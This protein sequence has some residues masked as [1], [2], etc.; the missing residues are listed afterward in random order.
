MTDNTRD[1]NDPIAHLRERPNPEVDRERLIE[2]F[3]ELK[4]LTYAFFESVPGAFIILDSR[5]HLIYLNGDAKKMFTDKEASLIGRPLEAISPKIFGH[6]L[7]PKVIKPLLEGKEETALKYSNLLHKWFKISA[8]ESE[9]AI[10]IRLEDM[11][12]E[13]I[14]S[15][16]LRLNE[17]SVSRAKDMVFWVKTGGH[18]IYANTA[19]C[20][21]LKYSREDLVKMKMPELDPSFEGY[22]WTKF[23][24]GMKRAGSMTYESSLRARDG[25]VI[26]VE[27]TCNYLK[28]SDDEYMMAFAR[29][30]TARKRTEKDL[31]EAKDG[32][33]IIRG[34]DGP[35]YQQHEPGRNRLSRDR[36]RY[37]AN[38][39][40]AGEVEY[41]PARQAP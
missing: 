32:S 6:I 31:L 17:F 33:G 2:E 1:I 23:V 4:A 27:V 15:R 22:G 7:A 29:D 14:T 11:T 35:R 24:D 40:Q 25:S 8:Y 9:S 38:G 26:P 41:Q 3:M 12:K 16:L 20:D 36:A 19:S 28:Y 5:W 39:G 13:Q 10:F 30:I 34:P 37:N 18:I 21:S